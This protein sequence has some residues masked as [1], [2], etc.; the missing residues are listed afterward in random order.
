MSGLCE[1]G[2]GEPTPIATRNRS[3]IGHVKGQP[4]RFLVGHSTK[5]RQIATRK[6]DAGYSAIH[7]WI[8][9]YHP[10]AGR[11]E[12]CGA[13]GKTEYAFRFHPEPHT[14]NRDDYRELCRPCHAVFDAVLHTG[15]RPAI[16]G[17]NHWR[18]R[19]AA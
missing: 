5:G 4:I 3:R 2:C 6:V 1:C 9:K 10:K 7:Y 11:C 12:E 16:A 17:D 18:R 8:R 14:R 13:E 15:P 19:R